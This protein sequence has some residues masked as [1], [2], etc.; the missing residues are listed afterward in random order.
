MT[1]GDRC[2]RSN[3]HF[4]RLQKEDIMIYL[5]YYP[6]YKLKD[7]TDT[8]EEAFNA[9]RAALPNKIEVR[10]PICWAED[11]K[12]FIVK[13]KQ[14]DY[15]NKADEEL[16]KI[17]KRY[18]S[19]F[20]KKEGLFYSFN[21]PK[22]SG[23]YRLIEAPHDETMEDYRRI[24]NIL[25][26]KVKILPHDAAWAYV[27]QRDIR[28]SLQIHQANQSKWFLKIDLKD[29]F[30]SFNEKSIELLLSRVHPL[31]FF[32]EFVE[33]LSQFA[34]YN[35]HLP[36]GT[37]LSPYL[38]NVMMIPF[39][40]K[41][42]Q[43]CAAAGMVYTRYADDILI[44]SQNYFNFTNIT[45]TIEEEAIEK[46]NY[47][48]SINRKKTRYGSINGKNWNL[49]LM[50]NQNNE[51]TVGH[52]KKRELKTIIHKTFHNELQPNDDSIV[53]LFSYVKHIEPTY[54]E[55]LDNWTIKKYGL[56][57]EEIINPK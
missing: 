44:S 50:L 32:P 55:F 3:T 28:G 9:L 4:Q 47:P 37:P 27:Q 49:G 30:G 40:H 57:I 8:L 2:T 5:T 25:E 10:R 53:G 41:V 24:K 46:L 45:T 13:S 14:R 56:M 12:G 52:E 42:T 11:K 16:R 6:K 18:G 15:V 23:G 38:T 7:K 22:S 39:D 19:N 35:D 20:K 21:I 26:L 48:F 29:F 36:Q 33:R 43:I 54:Y 31:Q 1:S 51:I 34:V 17:E